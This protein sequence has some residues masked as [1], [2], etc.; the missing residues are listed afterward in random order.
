MKN[1]EI[2]ASHIFNLRLVHT[3]NESNSR[4]VKMCPFI[5]K[6]LWRSIVTFWNVWN[7]SIIYCFFCSW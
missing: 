7:E 1:N 5:K 6:S 4:C 3:V 2:H